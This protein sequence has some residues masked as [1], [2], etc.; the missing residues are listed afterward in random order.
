[1]FKSLVLVLLV[2]SSIFAVPAAYSSHQ[3]CGP[4]YLETTDP[5]T[6]FVHCVFVEKVVEEIST[7]IAEFEFADFQEHIQ[8]VVNVK[9]GTSEIMVSL[10]SPNWQD[11]LIPPKLEKVIFNS[12]RHL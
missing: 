4:G 12:E 6:G 5:E 2:L 9:K 1:M 3:V 8:V 7:E 11:I 10:V